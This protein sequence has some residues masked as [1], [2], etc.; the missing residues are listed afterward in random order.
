LDNIPSEL[1]KHEKNLPFKLSHIDKNAR[2]REYK[3]MFVENVVSQCLRCS[4]HKNLFYIEY[5][6]AG[7]IVMEI[8]FLIRKDKKV[9]PIEA[10]S[11]KSFAIKSLH[12][13]KKKFSDK[14]GLQYV[15]YNGD[16]K[17]EQEI[18]YLPVYMAAVM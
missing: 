9:V 5:N 8:D 17:R 7:K 11:E 6:D 2:Q 1:S 13:F 12:S 16:I 4:G 10:K 15:L 14:V 3:G 18:I